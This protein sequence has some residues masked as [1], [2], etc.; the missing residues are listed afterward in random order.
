MPVGT[1]TTL[2]ANDGIDMVCSIGNLHQSPSY[3]QSNLNKD[4][5][6][7]S[8]PSLPGGLLSLTNVVNTSS[9]NSKQLYSCVPDIRQGAFRRCVNQFVSDD[10]TVICP[11][12]KQYMA[13]PL[14]YV[15]RQARTEVGSLSSCDAAEQECGIVKDVVTYMIMDDLQVKP[16]STNAVLNSLTN[17]FR[18]L[19]AS[20]HTKTA[21]TQ[22]FI[23][24]ANASRGN[25]VITF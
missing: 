18:L 6:L 24:D 3:L 14:T 17:G 2:L 19:K 8:M 15:Y 7:R 22:C 20:L 11:T 16:I 1:I 5:L 13:K 21:L 10:P 12:C 4:T 9:K 23:V 25:N